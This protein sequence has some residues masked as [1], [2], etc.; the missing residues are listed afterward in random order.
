MKHAD[1]WITLERCDHDRAGRVQWLERALVG[2]D[3][4]V[5]IA[6]LAAI[7]GTPADSAEVPAEEVRSWLGADATA[8]LE[9]GLE[10]LPKQKLDELFGR[11]ALLAGLQELALTE[12][13]QH[14]NNLVR[15]D[16][17]TRGIASEQQERVLG[18][19]GRSMPGFRGTPPDAARLPR[20]PAGRAP[21]PT[22]AGKGI[23]GPARRALFLHGPLA[24]V[25]AIL[26]AALILSDRRAPVQ[27]PSGGEERMVIVSAVRAD[28]TGG[29]TQPE[30]SADDGWPAHPLQELIAF[31]KGPAQTK[32]EVLDRLDGSREWFVRLDEAGDLS[33]TQLQ[34]AAER[35]RDAVAA[36]ETLAG[37]DGIDFGDDQ[38]SL[39]KLKCTTA[40]KELDHLQSMI[41]ADASRSAGIRTA[42]ADISRLLKDVEGA[43]VEACSDAGPARRSSPEDGK[44]PPAI[45]DP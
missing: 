17:A 3:L 24:A 20:D 14:W 18:N 21:D 35:A 28:E 4:P 36:I 33:A 15:R 27:Q 45:Q 38:R 2:L 31:G 25:A 8:V 13:G 39:L 37:S 41:A 7:G 30:P 19:A 44:D 1:S 23:A 42:K 5:A 40:K 9:Q 12:G 29:R 10:H 11:P 34:T 26:M 22:P 32:Q 43:L 16:E 6:E